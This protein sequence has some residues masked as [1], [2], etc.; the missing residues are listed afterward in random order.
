MLD[1]QPGDT[2]VTVNLSDDARSFITHREPRRMAKFIRSLSAGTA[3][4]V[5]H[6]RAGEALRGYYPTEVFNRYP[7]EV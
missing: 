7:Q 2:Y 4:T 1:H 3:V 5:L 6:I